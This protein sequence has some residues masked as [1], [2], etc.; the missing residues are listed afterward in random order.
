MSA[1]HGAAALA[2]SLLVNANAGI[3]AALANGYVFTANA[4]PASAAGGNPLFSVGM[5]PQAGNLLLAGVRR[6]ST[7]RRNVWQTSY[8]RTWLSARLVRHSKARLPAGIG[9]MTA[10][11]PSTCCLQKADESAATDIGVLDG[12]FAQMA[13]A[14]PHVT[15]R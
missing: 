5:G 14:G 3:E 2:P 6:W 11:S 15:S 9:C 10:S 8:S 1:D 4:G 7:R 12:Y 13:T